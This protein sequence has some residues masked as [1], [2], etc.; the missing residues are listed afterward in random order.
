[1]LEADTENSP[2]TGYIFPGEFL[3][4]LTHAFVSIKVIL[5]DHKE[6]T[7]YNKSLSINNNRE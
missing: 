1:M 4:S 5:F 2:T 3:S 6:F 7:Y